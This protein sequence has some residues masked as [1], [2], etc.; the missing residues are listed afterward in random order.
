M[1]G[2]GDR[3]LRVA[4][5]Y[6]FNLER[7]FLFYLLLLHEFFV[8]TCVC[9]FTH[10]HISL[11]VGERGVWLEF[12]A[13]VVD[14]VL[15]VVAFSCTLPLTNGS[16]RTK[17]AAGTTIPTT[18]TTIAIAAISEQQCQQQQQIQQPQQ[19]IA[20]CH[21]RRHVAFADKPQ[22]QLHQG[23]ASRVPATRIP[24]AE[25]GREQNLHSACNAFV[26]YV[27]ASTAT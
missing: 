2:L 25:A 22:L 18:T 12:V 16:N 24:S 19:L 23:K 10:T 4:V 6:L 20:T 3:S 15:I 7:V 14:V 11:E 1:G 13:V 26:S 27:T 17:A 5:Y 9:M 21:C 8:S